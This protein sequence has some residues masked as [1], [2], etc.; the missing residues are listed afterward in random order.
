MKDFSYL[1]E[2]NPY[3]YDEIFDWNVYRVTPEELNNANVL[4]IGGHY[5]F[6]S[7]L[8]AAYNAKRILGVEA[9]PYNYLQYINTTKDCA[10]VRAINAALYKE[11]N[12]LVSIANDSEKSILGKGDINVATV[13]LEQLLPYF[14]NEDVFLKM[15]IE[16]AE[17]DIL[18]NTSVPT[19]R[20]FS[21]IAIEMH[22]FP[23]SPHKFVELDAHIRYCGFATAWRGVFYTKYDD[24]VVVDNNIIEVYKYLRI[25]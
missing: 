15:D 22:E 7:C 4:D 16:G 13:T 3:V 23:D 14:N 12:K 25:N 18:Y 9:N 21:T 6:F 10:N 11:P 24:N 1:K 8:C 17:Y 5:G 2:I 20:R 19:L